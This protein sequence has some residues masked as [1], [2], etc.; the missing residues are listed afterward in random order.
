M[1]Q[2]P[3]HIQNLPPRTYNNTF[4]QWKAKNLKE[5]EQRVWAIVVIKAKL[6]LVDKEERESMNA[7]PT[8]TSATLLVT[9]FSWTLKYVVVPSG[10]IL[11]P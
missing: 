8:K 5:W 7:P 6:M 1:A 2:L 10:I 11:L 4:S 9:T 3:Q